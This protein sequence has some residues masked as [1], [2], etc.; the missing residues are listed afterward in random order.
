MPDYEDIT[1]VNKLLSDAQDDDRDNRE[2]VREAHN[3]LDKRDGQWEPAIVGSMSGR[4]RYTFDKC[5]PIVD[6]IAGEIDQA[7]FDIRVRPS[8]GDSTK[9]LAKTFDG[10]IRNIETMSNASTLYA[11]QGREMVA[12]GLGGWEVVQDW[13]DGDSFE[14]DLLIKPIWNFEDRVW[15]DPAAEMQDMS[16]ARYV[17]V[18][19]NLTPDEYDQKFPKGSKTSI[20]DDRSYTSYDRK[21][22]FIKVGRI[23]YKREVSKTLVLMSD[24]SVRERTDEFEMVVDE[25]ADQGITIVNERKRKSTEVV[26]RLFDGSDFLNDK[27]P[28]VFGWLP[29]VPTFGNY[30][31]RESKIIYRGAIDKLIDPQRVYNYARSRETEEVALAPRAKYWMTRK[32]AANPQ[33]RDRLSTLNT[34]SDPVQFYTP[35]EEA[36]GAPPQLGGAVAN[37][38]LQLVVQNSLDDIQTSSGRFGVQSGDLNSQ[39][40]GVAIQ[41]LQNKGDNGSIKYFKSQEVAICHTARILINAIPKVY[42]TKRQARILNEDGSFEMVTINDQVFDQQTMTMVTVNDLRKGKY[43][44]T[45]DVGPAFKNRQQES[46][47]ALQEL[48]QVIPGIAELTAD[49]Q[50][51]NIASPGIDIATERV[52]RRL[53]ES[54]Q[55]PESQLTKEEKEEVMVAQQAAQQQPEQQ[56]P[57]AIIAE[58]EVGRVQAETADTISR[59][60]ERQVKA[61]QKDRELL[62]KEQDQLLSAQQKAGNLELAELKLLLQQQAQQA[63]NQQ[64]MVQATIQGQQAI[65]DSLNTQAQTL[66]TL[67]EAM[68]VDTIVSPPVIESFH[69]QAEMIT[70]NQE[71]MESG[72][73]HKQGTDPMLEN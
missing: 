49:I 40:S 47:K 63:S 35:D 68:G 58:A 54:G 66:K 24:E 61:S 50:L 12:S 31:I 53:F 20:G 27:Q 7:D 26:S 56:D 28:T 11:Q 48:A 34:N 65:V 52:R 22:E 30:K 41:S 72:M 44:V 64:A 71:Q 59:S 51:K 37:P 16:D 3:F 5:N 55:I 13:A 21:P 73:I 29:I 69:E 60:Q 43:D 19:Q 67:R 18:L 32:Q 6:D 4:P 62:L 38:G 10:L 9:D 2:I 45:C 14:Q 57:A 39:L 1:V 17:F 15:F 33:D 25:L 70:D 42:D 8:G 23:L 46:V 36:P